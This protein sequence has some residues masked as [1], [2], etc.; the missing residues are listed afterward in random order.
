VGSESIRSR[1]GRQRNSEVRRSCEGITVY[2][3]GVRFQYVLLGRDEV[4][5]WEAILVMLV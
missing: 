4:L 1:V 2:V 3:S 5:T